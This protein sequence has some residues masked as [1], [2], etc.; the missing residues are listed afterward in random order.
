MSKLFEI[1]ILTFI[2]VQ[3]LEFEIGLPALLNL[4]IMFC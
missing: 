2:A 3:I 1:W 4:F